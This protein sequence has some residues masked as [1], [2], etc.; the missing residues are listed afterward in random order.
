MYSRIILILSFMIQFSNMA[1]ASQSR[2]VPIKGMIRS[3]E[4]VVIGKIVRR[5]P[6]LEIKDGSEKKVCGWSLEVEVNYSFKGG[7]QS[8]ELY[9]NDSD[10]F[11]G[12]NLD[13]FI[14]AFN[15]PTYGTGKSSEVGNCAKQPGLEE[16]EVQDPNGPPGK[17]LK[18]VMLRPYEKKY[19]ELDIS[20]IK[21]SSIM[22]RFGHE[23]YIFAL[24][25]YSKEKFGDNWLMQPKAYR[26]F[27]KVATKS[28]NA[29]ENESYTEPY[30]ALKFVDVLKE[31]LH[32]KYNFMCLLLKR[33]EITIISFSITML[34]S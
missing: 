15:N 27:D 30:T 9:T 34:F 7:N 29:G 2:V 17:M 3:A 6:F 33:L 4:K 18:Y 23:Q 21:Y 25:P 5:T 22:G 20:N 8:F 26:L 16:F 19:S 31:V 10:T 13:Y 1:I 32:I 28:I 24:D 11:A 14:I 12:D